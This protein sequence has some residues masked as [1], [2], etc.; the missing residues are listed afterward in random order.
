[1]AA[2]GGCRFD[3]DRRTARVAVYARNRGILARDRCTWK[4]RGYA[5]VTVPGSL[6]FTSR[7]RLVVRV[8]L[9]C[10]YGGP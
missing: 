4:K 3:V 7:R 10:Y 5:Q 2:L 1:M 9:A 8:P 6:F